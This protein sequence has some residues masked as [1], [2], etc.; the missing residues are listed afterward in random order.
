MLFR[1]KGDYTEQA[2]KERI[3]GTRTVKPRRTSPPKPVSKVGLLVDIEAAVRSGKGPGYERWAKVFNLS[4]IHIC[5]P[6]QAI[7]GFRGAHPDV[8]SALH[9]AWPSLESVTLAASHRSA[10]GIL[11]SASALLGP[12]SACGKLI[13]TR[14]M[15]ACLHL[16]S[17]PDARKEAEA[18][19]RIP[20]AERWLAASVTLSSEGHASCRAD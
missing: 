8:Q 16:F 13:P 6:D 19:V 7:Y 18:E 1:S 15:E 20:A 11:T 10:A 9:E 3:A 5:D 12:S 14:N 2:I 17:A 4:L